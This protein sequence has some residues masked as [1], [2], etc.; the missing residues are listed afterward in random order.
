MC[1]YIYMCILCIWGPTRYIGVLVGCRCCLEYRLFGRSSFLL[2]V[3]SG[4]SEFDVQA[5]FQL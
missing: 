1:I 3:R 2:G 5:V 4:P